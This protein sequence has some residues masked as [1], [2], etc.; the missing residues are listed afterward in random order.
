MITMSMI[1]MS[2]IF[3]MLAAGFV[4]HSYDRDDSNVKI[5]NEDDYVGDGFQYLDGV[6]PIVSFKN[7]I[8]LRYDLDY[9]RKT[10]KIIKNIG[11]PDK[12]IIIEIIKPE[13]ICYGGGCNG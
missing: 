1:T 13:I 11:D 4:I 7:P 3:L 8:P 2:M 5:L 12:T 6:S 9:F 10:G